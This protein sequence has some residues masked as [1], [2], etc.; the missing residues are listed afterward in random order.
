MP[1]KKLLIANR[2][3]ISIR[4]A[5]TAAAMGIATVAVH[6]DDDAASLH[7]RRADQS[8]ALKGRGVA[9]Y[10]IFADRA[11]IEM[12]ARKPKTRDA[13]ATIP[14][15]GAAKL[16]SFAEMFLNTIKNFESQSAAG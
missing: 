4:I 7:T 16:K 8:W 1:V 14:G 5:R 10:L 13:F 2:G 6:A 12:A 3:E 11:L 9:A 15:V